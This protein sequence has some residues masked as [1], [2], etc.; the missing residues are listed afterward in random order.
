MNWKEKLN[1]FLYPN[2]K[3]VYGNFFAAL[4]LLVLVHYC[5]PDS[6]IALF[7]SLVYAAYGLTL[8]CFSLP[9]VVSEVFTR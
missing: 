7:L 3:W 2:I 8:L 6:F 5:L 4:A 1:D 9:Q